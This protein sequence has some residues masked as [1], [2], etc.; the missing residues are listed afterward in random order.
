MTKRPREGVE[1]KTQKWVSW[2]ALRIC[3]NPEALSGAIWSEAI[4]ACGSGDFWV[5]HTTSRFVMK[6]NPPGV[7]ASASTP[8]TFYGAG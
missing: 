7:G 8:G 1:S 4:L 3:G 5:D 2:R 6:L